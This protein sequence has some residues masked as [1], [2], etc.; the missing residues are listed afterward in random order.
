MF[1]LVWS[2]YLTTIGRNTPFW[3]SH[4]NAMIENSSVT[5][6]AR[7]LPGALL[8]AFARRDRMAVHS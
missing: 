4:P 8:S 2:L 6:I 7:M 1:T 3:R 5:S